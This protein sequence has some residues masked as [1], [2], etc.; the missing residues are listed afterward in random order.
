MRRSA[1]IASSASP[2]SGAL[3]PRLVE[4]CGAYYYLPDHHDRALPRAAIGEPDP[5]ASPSPAR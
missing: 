4:G 1:R 3:D 2:S 5:P